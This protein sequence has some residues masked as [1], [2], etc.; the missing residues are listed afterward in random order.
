MKTGRELNWSVT[1]YGATLKKGLPITIDSI[2]ATARSNGAEFEEVLA[3]SYFIARPEGGF[4]SIFGRLHHAWLVLT[5]KAFAVQFTRDHLEMAG[6]PVLPQNRGTTVFSSAVEAPDPSS[7]RDGG[8]RVSEAFAKRQAEPRW[9][10][11]PLLATDAILEAIAQEDAESDMYAAMMEAAAEAW[12]KLLAVAPKRGE[13]PPNS[14]TW[15]PDAGNGFAWVPEELTDEMAQVLE[16]ELLDKELAAQAWKDV[17]SL[18]SAQ[19]SARTA[20]GWPA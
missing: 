8:C 10:R 11:A 5:S 13:A 2:C 12:P 20:G 3:E 9:H 16:A 4:G 1:R 6:V 14:F 18:L 7:A 15:S 19:T 17:V